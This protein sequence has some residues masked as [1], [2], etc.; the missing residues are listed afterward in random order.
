MSV[1]PIT[2]S[3]LQPLRGDKRWAYLTRARTI[4]VATLNEDST[5][6]LS[7][8]WFVVHEQKI[9]LPIDAASRHGAN[10]QA[11]RALSALV[12]SG[13]EYATV[14][15]VR[16]SGTMRKVTDSALLAT[17]GRLVFDK[18]F[19]VGHPY[20]EQYAEFGEVAGRSYYELVPDKMIGWDM[21]EINT[22]AMPE[23]R[24]LPGHV[25]DRLL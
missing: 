20:A 22:I 5:I 24:S 7:P 8:L 17:L 14:S 15:G 10:F 21:R 23:T 9:Y 18:Y 1:K 19:Y 13:E 25:G 16:I 6:Y 11:G 3:K 4:R 12:D 2:A